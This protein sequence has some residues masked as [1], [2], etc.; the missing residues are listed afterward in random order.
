MKLVVVGAQ[1]RM[2]QALV[3]A[4]CESEWRASKRRH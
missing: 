3:R 1:G 2:G 4:I